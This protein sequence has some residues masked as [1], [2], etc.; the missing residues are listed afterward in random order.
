MNRIAPI[1]L[2]VI[3]AT[4][5]THADPWHALVETGAPFYAM[6]GYHVAASIEAP[7][8]PRWRF[9]ATVF[10]LD[11][12]QSFIDPSDIGWTQHDDG[13]GLG[14]EHEFGSGRSGWIAA[15]NLAVQRRKASHVDG[16]GSAIEEDLELA[17]GYRW[18]PSRALGLTV[19]P[20]LGF[21]L[22]LHRSAAPVVDG[23]TY[24]YKPV[25]VIPNVTVG[26]QF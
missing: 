12:P 13:V 5:T 25:A 8:L 23:M 14:A 3:T 19:A 24:T 10:G 17:A 11:I 21:A 9:G 4:T 26:W 16:S 22:P 18:F 20:T 2:L 7:A 1:L 6:G 15:A